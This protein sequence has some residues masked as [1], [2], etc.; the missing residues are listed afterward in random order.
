[1]THANRNGGR[2]PHPIIPDESENL[3]L[4]LPRLLRSS[5]IMDRNP[6]SMDKPRKRVRVDGHHVMVV[7]RDLTP[8]FV[9]R[10]AVASIP[11]LRAC[12]EER[13]TVPFG[14]LH[15][16]VMVYEL[17]EPAALLSRPVAWDAVWRCILNASS[18][19]PIVFPVPQDADVALHLWSYLMADEEPPAVLL[20]AVEHRPFA[21]LQML[22]HGRPPAGKGLADDRR[23]ALCSRL[24]REPDALACWRQDPALW[25]A[26]ARGL[27]LHFW[28][29]A[30]SAAFSTQHTPWWLHAACAH[31]TERRAM[32]RAMLTHQWSRDAQ[33]MW[34]MD[35]AGLSPRLARLASETTWMLLQPQREALRPTACDSMHPGAPQLIWHEALQATQDGRATVVDT[36]LREMRDDWGMKAPLPDPV[37]AF[38]PYVW[39]AAADA[40]QQGLLPSPCVD[41]TKSQ[42]ASTQAQGTCPRRARYMEMGIFMGS[43][44]YAPPMEALRMLSIDP[45]R[46]CRIDVHPH[47][48][49]VML[50]PPE[51]PGCA[52]SGHAEQ[53]H[54]LLLWYGPS[55]IDLAPRCIARDGTAAVVANLAW[56]AS[57]GASHLH[58]AAALSSRG[59]VVAEPSLVAWAGGVLAAARPRATMSQWPAWFDHAGALMEWGRHIAPLGG[60]VVAAQRDESDACFLNTAVRHPRAWSRD[61]QSCPERLSLAVQE[62]SCQ[63][64][65]HEAAWRNILLHAPLTPGD[66]AD[67]TDGTYML[68][69]PQGP[70][71]CSVPLVLSRNAEDMD[72]TLSWEQRQRVS[73]EF[74]DYEERL[75][76]WLQQGLSDCIP[77]RFLHTVLL[78]TGATWAL[79]KL[80][81]L[82]SYVHLPMK[83]WEQWKSCTVQLAAVPLLT[84]RT[85]RHPPP[86]RHQFTRR[87]LVL[88]LR[89][90]PHHIEAVE[91]V[92]D[93]EEDDKEDE[94]ACFGTDWQQDSMCPSYM[95]PELVL[96]ELPSRP[97]W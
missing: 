59:L 93:W 12:M 42:G 72:N 46:V 84:I 44:A 33:G 24:P 62:T 3:V 91:Y 27:Y 30:A 90:I 14:S 75:K 61:A 51:V 29:P 35:G 25:A 21:L 68:L 5:S 56:V 6:Q 50:R 77:R 40:L 34:T 96:Q 57:R 58:D 15:C 55:P 81:D 76:A 23:L 8:Q 41:V 82:G 11:F 43:G 53:R 65:L 86:R 89:L 88:S 97:Q 39:H 26:G 85:M 4:P 16:N 47:L 78:D 20:N 79:E 7:A 17:H 64:V 13:E 95:R 28:L 73:S 80:G 49:I 63:E 69:F 71:C 66:V 54:R 45:S 22:A 83:D 37:T 67:A 36:L 52:T 18:H 87:L 10:H 32:E 70:R 94:A 74:A 9:P 31:G 2:A 19:T 60:G 48:A 92:A 1:M 38:G